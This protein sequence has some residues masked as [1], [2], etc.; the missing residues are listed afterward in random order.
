VILTIDAGNSSIA[1]GIFSGPTLLTTFSIPTAAIDSSICL[2]GY[3]LE[4][5]THGGIDVAQVRRCM[6]CSVVGEINEHIESA[7]RSCFKKSP[8]VF[9][10]SCDHGIVSRYID[11][12]QLG[13]DRLAGMIGAAQ[14][15]PCRNL[16]VID[17]GTAT[18]LDVLTH[19]RVHHGGAI[20]PGAGLMATC[21]E[22]R[23]SRLEHIYIRP[24]RA[25]AGR[26]TAACL[27]GGIYI[28]LLG[29]IRELRN[30][31]ANEY[32]LNVPWYCVAAGGAAELYKDEN[33]YDMYHPYLVLE[34]LRAALETGK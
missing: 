26:S 33:L 3:L 14:R 21:L 13:T 7:C 18:T 31:L 12:A 9:D 15:Y 17:C 28:G 29:A 24:P 16:I 2:S 10:Y 6:Y 4:A 34:G 30:K 22:Q 25:T 8:E 1:C 23:T 11:P 5:L 19:R 20:L 32:F 27:R